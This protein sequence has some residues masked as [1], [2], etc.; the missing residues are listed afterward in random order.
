MYL[1]DFIQ[2]PCVVRGIVVGCCVLS[3]VALVCYRVLISDAQVQVCM[4]CSQTSHTGGYVRVVDMLHCLG[5]LAAIEILRC[6]CDLHSSF[7]FVRAVAAVFFGRL[8]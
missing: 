5:M 4:L 1:V 2:S 6:G 3:C 7:A 8:A